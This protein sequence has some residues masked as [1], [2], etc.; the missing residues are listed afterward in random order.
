MTLSLVCRNFP[1]T[2]SVG[3]VI[4]RIVHT[5]YMLKYSVPPYK[6]SHDGDL[7]PRICLPLLSQ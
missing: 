4:G 7:A 2:V 3:R 6:V 5:E 1:K